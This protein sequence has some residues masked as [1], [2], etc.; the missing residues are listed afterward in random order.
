MM[1]C[2]EAPAQLVYDFSLDDHV[3]SDHLLRGIVDASLIAADDAN[4]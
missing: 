2:Q 1:A 3:P 4:K